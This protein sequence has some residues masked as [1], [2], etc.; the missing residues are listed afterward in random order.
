[1]V[2]SENVVVVVV[3]FLV[4]GFWYSQKRSP[5]YWILPWSAQ[6]I[7]LPIPLYYIDEFIA[8]M[9]KNT[10]QIY[11]SMEVSS[12]RRKEGAPPTHQDNNGKKNNLAIRNRES[13]LILNRVQAFIERN[14]S[15]NYWRKSN[16]YIFVLI[17]TN[18]LKNVL[19]D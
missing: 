4:F 9:S 16:S 7:Y 19:Q 6:T 11:C 3:N 14:C 5:V 18:R 1:M 12:P 15:K 17:R 10:L 13:T 2:V 8:Y